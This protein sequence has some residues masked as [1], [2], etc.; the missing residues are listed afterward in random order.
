[1]IIDATNLIAGRIATF[2]AKKALLGE[3]IEIINCEK[4]VISGRAKRTIADFKQKR[5]RGTPTKGPFYPK[6]PE[7]IMKRMI[8]GMLPYKKERGREA[9][10]RIMC[11]KGVPEELKDKETTS[12]KGAEASKL[13]IPKLIT[14]EQISKQLGAKL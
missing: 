6:S 8:R 11:Y 3:K 1:M 12:I 7:R 10:K 9:M 5:E 2:A 14:I 4:A 13:M